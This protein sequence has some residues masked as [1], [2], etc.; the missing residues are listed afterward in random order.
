[1]RVG[2][3][4]KKTDMEREKK[5]K[6]IEILILILIDMAFLF[7]G[8]LLLVGAFLDNKCPLDF[9]ICWVCSI[10]LTYTIHGLWKK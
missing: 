7:I 5:M 9:V 10:I 4:F 2:R 6:Y 3:P 8:G 1:M